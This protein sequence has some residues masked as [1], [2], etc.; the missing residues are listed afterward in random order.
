M[1]KQEVTFSKKIEVGGKTFEGKMQFESPDMGVI[2]DVGQICPPTN[3]VGFGAAIIGAI[4]D[5]PYTSIRAMSPDEFMVL[6]AAMEPLLP[7]L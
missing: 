1:A 4:V 2:I 3:Q 5:V 6:Q 7:K